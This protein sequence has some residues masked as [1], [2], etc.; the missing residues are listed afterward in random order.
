PT[1]GTSVR[2]HE[3]ARGFTRPLL[4]ISPPGDPRLFVVEQVGR[5]SII[6]DGVRLGEPFLDV[7]DRV[8]EVGNEQGLL[9]LAFHPDYA[10]NGRFS[11]N[12]IARDPQG[13]TVVAEYRVSPDDADRA[14]AAS[15]RRLIAGGALDQPASN[16]NGGMLAFG[17][18]GYLYIG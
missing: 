14:D 13:D 9:G 2:L 1:P 4:A 5:I 3:V 17:P 10:R 15:E 11:V 8:H 7:R 18:D 6:R 12:Y 16:H